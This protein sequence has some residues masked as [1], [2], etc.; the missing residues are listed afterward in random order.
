[1]GGPFISHSTLDT[2]R[3]EIITVEAYVYNPNNKKRNLMRQMEAI[4]YSFE[5]L[6]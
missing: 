4:V 6:K 2:A 1:M 3:N 5:L